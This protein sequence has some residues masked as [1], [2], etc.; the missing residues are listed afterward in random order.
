MRLRQGLR[1]F[2]ARRRRTVLRDRLSWDVNLT[3]SWARSSSL[4]RARPAGGL[5]GGLAW[6]LEQLLTAHDEV[7]HPCVDHVT[8]CRTCCP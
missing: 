2:S 4:Q 7:P 8:S 5:E 6:R 1:S 3:I